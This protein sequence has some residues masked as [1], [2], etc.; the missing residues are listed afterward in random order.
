MTSFEK[1]LQELVDD[2]NNQIDSKTKEKE[3]DILKV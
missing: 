2:A 3:S 1:K